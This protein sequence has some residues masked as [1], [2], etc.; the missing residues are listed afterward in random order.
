M[1]HNPTPSLHSAPLPAHGV[2]SLSAGGDISD[3]DK[4]R[5]VSDER[6]SARDLGLLFPDLAER[7]F[8]RDPVQ[9]SVY[10][11]TIG[12]F[13]D[14]L[15][16]DTYMRTANL[17]RALAIAASADRPVLLCGQPLGLAELLF[18]HLRAERPMPRQVLI[19][20]GGYA[21]PLGLERR[22]CERLSDAGVEH[23]V[24]HGYGMAEVAPAC[25]VGR[26]S[27]S[28]K[29]NYRLANRHV[30]V[31][32]HDGRLFL[33]RC[34]DGQPAMDS[35]DYARVAPASDWQGPGEA[36]HIEPSER[37]IAPMVR[38]AL[39]SWTAADWDRRTGYVVGRDD[40]GVWI[41]L[42][43]GVLSDSADELSFGLFEE[44]L[45]GSLLDKPR[46]G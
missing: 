43:R 14:V 27:S 22:I 31:E 30:A 33:R 23:D 32:I 12:S 24:I 34:S 3:L 29:I 16:I 40:G 18:E 21:C 2:L 11:A 8:L 5:L 46:W 7:G 35:G 6:R 4:W 17:A 42:R 13:A 1:T 44:Q 36:W 37:R 15:F 39:D 45:G 19:L 38:M 41:Q 9:V 25:L 20:I 26:R 10:P 28:G